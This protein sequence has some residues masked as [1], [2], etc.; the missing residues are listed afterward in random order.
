MI[1]AD[2]NKT[3]GGGFKFK[4]PKREGFR[5][6]DCLMVEH[7]KMRGWQGLEQIFEELVENQPKLDG[8]FYKDYAKEL[9]RQRDTISHIVC[10][11]RAQQPYA[12]KS[13]VTRG[14]RETQIGKGCK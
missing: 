12:D 2:C 3:L 7:D 11:Y 14:S 10:I 5:C 9:A 4:E 13:N 1:C 6:F 8:R